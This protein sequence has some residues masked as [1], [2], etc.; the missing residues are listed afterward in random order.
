MFNLISQSENKK[1]TSND[2]GLQLSP[3]DIKE[4]YR[5]KWNIHQKD[6][7]CLTKN[8]ELISDSLYRVGGLGADIKDNYFMLLKHIESFYSDSITKIGKDKP[9]MESRWCI[10]DK[11]GVEKVEFPALKNP[12]LV[13]DS[14]IYSIDSK[15]YN[16]ETGEFYCNSHSSMVSTDYL[17]LQNDYDEN[18]SRRG[19]MRINKKD[20][21][22]V[23][24]S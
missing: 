16:I 6:F 11:N 9:H 17:F 15:Y 19:V 20:G 4:D 21:T 12:Y 7:V 10:L 8:G 23:L 13:K 5:K 24:F 2:C 3:I 22:W 14:Q 1:N 18:K